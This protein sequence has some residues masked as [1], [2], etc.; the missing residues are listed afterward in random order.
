MCAGGLAAAANRTSLPK[1]RSPTRLSNTTRIKAFWVAGAAVLISSKNTSDMPSCPAVVCAQ[2]GGSKTTPDA[3]RTG[4]PEKSV[5]SWID[6]IT[7]TVGHPACCANASMVRVLPVPG[8]PH[9]S[10]GM[11][12]AS[13]ICIA[14]RVSPWVEPA[15]VGGLWLK[16][17]QPSSDPFLSRGLWSRC[18][19]PCGGVSPGVVRGCGAGGGVLAGGVGWGAVAAAPVRLRCGCGGGRSRRLRRRAPSSRH[20]G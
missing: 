17:S 3:V 8:S 18:A 11:P 9:N 1:S 7:D 4:S 12:A 15:V 20:R 5:G 10:T 13:R 16:W 2:A 19:R 14:T 6:A